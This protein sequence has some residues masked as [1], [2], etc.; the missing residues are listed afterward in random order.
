MEHHLTKSENNNS[1]SVHKGDTVMIELEETPTSG[2]MWN[3]AEIN[4]AIA[5]LQSSNYELAS[6]AMGGGG[7]RKFVFYITGPGNGSI[8]LKNLRQWSGDV[9]ET[10]SVNLQCL[11]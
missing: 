6:P 3:I 4:S 7:K 8:S 2:Y 10:F 11:N 1:L 9:A 5:Q